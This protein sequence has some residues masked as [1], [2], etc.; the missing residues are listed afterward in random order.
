MWAEFIKAGIGGVLW[1]GQS[2]AIV[3]LIIKLL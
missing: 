1:C 3:M 2:L